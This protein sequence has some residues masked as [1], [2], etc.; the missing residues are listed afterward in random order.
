[1]I[2]LCYDNGSTQILC[3]DNGSTQITDKE[4]VMKKILLGILVGSLMVPLYCGPANAG[5]TLEQ[6]RQEIRTNTG[7]TLKRLYKLAPQS[8]RVIE[9]AVGYG[10]FN[11]F[12]LK[13]LVTGS[14]SG[15]GMVVDNRSKKEIFMK[16]YKMGAGLGAGVKKFAWVYVFQSRQAFNTFVNKGWEFGADANAAAKWSKKGDAAGGGIQVAEGIIV[17]QLVD[18]GLTLDA[19]V[20]GTKYWQ[21]DELNGKPVE[22]N[23]LNKLKYM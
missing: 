1:M 4:G 8:K 17:Y 6:R 16:M 18:K 21:N 3:Y 22:K 14:T 23:L 10:V 20:G 2:F 19:M 5:K 15:K 11:L 9:K 13:I 7:Q 12:S